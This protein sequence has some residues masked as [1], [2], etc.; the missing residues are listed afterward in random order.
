MW[1]TL[2]CDYLIGVDDVVVNGLGHGSL[3]SPE[4]AQN[5]NLQISVA[6]KRENHKH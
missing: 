6:E 5:V 3:P 1:I 2:V 4:S